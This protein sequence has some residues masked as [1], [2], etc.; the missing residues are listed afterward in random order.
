MTTRA[1]GSRAVALGAATGLRTFMAPTVLSQAASR[2]RLPGMEDTRFSPLTSSW[3][4]NLFAVA[5]LGELVVDKL[6]FAPSRT[7]GGAVV[8]RLV[9]GAVSGAAFRAATGRN[10]LAGAALAGAGAVAAAYAGERYRALGA[11]AGIPDPVLAVLEDATA[12]GLALLAVRG[13]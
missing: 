11:G 3:V 8:G 12:V 5:A 9:S 10:V 7:Q 2:G 6:P 13:S 4:A 1:S